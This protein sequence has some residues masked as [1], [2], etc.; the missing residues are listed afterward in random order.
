M[1]TGKR[2]FALIQYALTFHMWKAIYLAYCLCLLD[3]EICSLQQIYICCYV[4]YPGSKSYPVKEKYNMVKVKLMT[5]TF[6][7]SLKICFPQII[8]PDFQFPSLCSPQFT[9]TPPIQT[10]PCLSIEN[11]TGFQ[12]IIINIII[13][14]VII[15][16]YYY[17]KLIRIN[18]QSKQ[19]EEKE[20]KKRHKTDI[21]L[22]THSRIP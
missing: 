13:R 12:R 15:K 14:Y 22:F 8:Y 21:H 19:T 16:C 11:K 10:Y 4:K 18:G 6:L 5:T 9:F 20:L 1:N 2:K 3:L 7:F 17:N